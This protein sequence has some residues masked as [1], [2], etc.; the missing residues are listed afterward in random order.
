[1]Q[2]KIRINMPEGQLQNVMVFTNDMLKML[3]ADFDSMEANEQHTL[4]QIRHAFN[5]MIRQF[6]EQTDDGHRTS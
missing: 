6:E 2:R 4:K 3:E 1:M 5:K